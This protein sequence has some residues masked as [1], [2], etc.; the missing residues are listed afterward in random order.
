M[1]SLLGACSKTQILRWK[2]R[3]SQADLVWA[4]PSGQDVLVCIDLKG[5]VSILTFSKGGTL[6]RKSS[7]TSCIGD[8]GI[9]PPFHVRINANWSQCR[10]SI[11]FKN[12]CVDT[13][14]ILCLLKKK[15]FGSILRMNECSVSL[16]NNWL[17]SVWLGYSIVQLNITFC[18]SSPRQEWVAHCYWEQ[19]GCVE[20]VA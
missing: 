2:G 18:S 5:E 20:A 13:W 4:V 6:R 14:L 1:H 16:I 10:K 9:L 3:L 8:A 17:A 11:F 15:K 12:N 19:R 7:Y